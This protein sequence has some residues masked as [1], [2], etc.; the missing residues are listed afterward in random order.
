M[1]ANYKSISMKDNSS[2]YKLALKTMKENYTDELENIYFNNGKKVSFDDFK[3][4]KNYKVHSNRL[5]DD[6][7]GLALSALST[8]EKAL[9][10]K[11]L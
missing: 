8:D 10:N 6:E 3:L 2:K 9:L 11:C 5:S 4:S 7:S 1:P